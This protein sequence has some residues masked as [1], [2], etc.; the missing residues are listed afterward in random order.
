MKKKISRL[1]VAVL[2]VMLSV[3]FIAPASIFATPVLVSI[4]VTPTDPEITALGQTQ[5]FT[6]SGTY[7]DDSTADITA[8]VAWSSTDLSVASIDAS[9]LATAVKEGFIG[10][11]ASLDGVSGWSSLTVSR[12]Y[13]WVDPGLPGESTNIGFGVNN[14]NG[15]AWALVVKDSS[16]V[17][18]YSSSGTVSSDG[19]W[20]YNSNTTLGADD[21]VAA[22][23]VGGTLQDTVNFSVWGHEASLSVIPGYSGEETKITL[24]ASSSSGKEATLWLLKYV[25]SG[26]YWETVDEFSTT[27]DSD[28]WSYVTTYSLAKGKYWASLVI[29]GKYEDG[30]EFTIVDKGIPQPPVVEKK[31]EKKQGPAIKKQGPA[32]NKKPAGSYDKNSS[33]FINLFYNRLLLRN[34]ESEG[35]NAW[36]SR[37]GD[38]SISDKDLV[39]KIIFGEEC[40]TRIGDYSDS[41]FITFLYSAIFNRNPEDLGYQA[42]M[43]R[44]ASGMTREEVVSGFSQSDEFIKLCESF[45]ILP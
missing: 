42:W 26:D 34:P 32:I 31:E 21:Y 38:G 1:L 6:A 7:A 12:P 4:E 13:L 11:E 20:D 2:V 14:C 17:T 18:V 45:G 9:G 40:Q 5:Q 44:M 3:V 33:G 8:L 25:A 30:K 39:K 28:P 10:I 22:L 36:I 27:I 15:L 41:E 37:I 29:N 35:L 19:W 43:D 23:T 16:D 24:N